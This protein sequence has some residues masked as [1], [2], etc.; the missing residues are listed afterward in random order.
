M[1][2]LSDLSLPDLWRDL[3]TAERLATLLPAQPA[4]EAAVHHARLQAV[5]EAGL[6]EI[7][8]RTALAERARAHPRRE[9]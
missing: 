4:E 6:G 2:T 7:A 1:T 8:R 3:R 9:G 5:R